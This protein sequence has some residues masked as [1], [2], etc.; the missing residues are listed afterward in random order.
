MATFEVRLTD[1]REVEIDAPDAKTAARVAAAFE[2][3]AK[4]STKRSGWQE[5][6]GATANVNRGLGIG[7]EL[8]AVGNTVGGFMTGRHKLQPDGGM[9]K[10]A[11]VV[12]E[13]FRN[14]LTSQRAQED[15]FAAR[16]PRAAALMQGVGNAAT[17]VVPGGAGARAIQGGGAMMTGV[18][19]ATASA[20][21]GA[22]YGLVDRGNAS[23][24]LEGANN[25]AALGALLGF[26]VGATAA[27]LTSRRSPVAETQAAEGAL[28]EAGLSIR[29]LTQTQQTTLGDLIRQGRS[30]REAALHVVASEGLPVPVPMTRG[31]RSGQPGQQIKE[32]LMLR[33][34]KGP[35]ASRQM[36][37]FVDEQQVA[38]R[39]NTEVIAADMAGAA[40]APERGAGGVA[41]SEALATRDGAMRR[42]VNEAFDAAR[43]ADDGV[44][45]PKEQ[46]PVLGARLAESLRS[47]DLQGVPRV[48]TEIDR[49][50]ASGRAGPTSVRELFDARA[51]LTNLRGS[52]DGVERGAAGAAVRELDTFI[53]EAV[54]ADL[55]TGGPESVGLWRDAISRSREHKQLFKAGDLIE[56][57]TER[58]AR[59]GDTRALVVAP[60]D[61]TNYILG[62]SDL[63]FVGRKNLYRDLARLRTVLGP[64]SAEWNT[65][66]AEVFQRLSSQAEGGV[67]FGQR[68]FSGVKF[69]KG[70]DDLNRKDARLAQ[71][72]FT[73]EERATIDRFATVSSRVTS[74]VKGGD[75]SSNTAVAAMRLLGNLRFLKGLPIIQGISNEVEAQ[76]TLGAARNATSQTVSRAPRSTGS[77]PPQAALQATGA[78]AAMLTSPYPR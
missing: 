13:A 51:R 19:A 53:D 52:A 24:R 15:D 7:D 75:N 40:R 36:R 12:G 69:A 66:R 33:G 50:D 38:L 49:L 74:P 25:A 34:A 45:L 27:K 14:E 21:T 61:A 42:G 30:G 63:G 67:E 78:G 5:A 2:T 60:E 32:N 46:T 77:G 62:R 29:T 39:G 17:V 70:W 73:P 64:E 68:Q 8:A 72:L 71:T 4:A 35:E 6:I 54:A 10:N 57:L 44:A 59:G 43:A 55:L 28:Q 37:G 18:R 48:A 3:K 26:G 11:S 1:G 65:L 76:I 20:A 58:S 9:I 31:Q 56:S 22:G 47:Y 23:E 41:V 16:R